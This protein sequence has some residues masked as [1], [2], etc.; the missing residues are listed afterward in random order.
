MDAYLQAMDGHV[1]PATRDMG[2]YDSA[3]EHLLVMLHN[4]CTFLISGTTVMN[5]TMTRKKLT[6]LTVWYI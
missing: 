6:L 3:N 4:A 5:K 2:T 1:S